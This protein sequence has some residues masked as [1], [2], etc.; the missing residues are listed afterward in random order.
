MK[1]GINLINVF[2][3]TTGENGEEH[4]SGTLDLNALKKSK[5]GEVRV[6]L[7]YGD[8]LPACLHGL[9]GKNAATKSGLFLFAETGPE[10]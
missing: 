9:I 10:K 5:K 7:M 8:H 4:F 1:P 2:E 6:V 3:R